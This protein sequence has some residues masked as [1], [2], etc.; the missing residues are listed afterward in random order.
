MADEERRFR[1]NLE[2]QQNKNDMM[3]Q[4]MRREQIKSG[5]EDNNGLPTPSKG[6]QT[7]S[8]LT[9]MSSPKM[10]RIRTLESLKAPSSQ[11]RE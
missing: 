9:K 5:K 2:V 1:A 11:E 6:Y 3:I 8:A 4:D 7:P 10:K